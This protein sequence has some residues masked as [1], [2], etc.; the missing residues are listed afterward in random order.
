M[1]GTPLHPLALGNVKTIRSMLDEHE[2]LKNIDIIGVGGIGDHAGF[3]RMESVGAR[4]VGVGT[5]LGREG[6]AVFGR[7]WEEKCADIETI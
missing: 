4:V 3:L 5:A 2:Q 7:S 6:P 1:A